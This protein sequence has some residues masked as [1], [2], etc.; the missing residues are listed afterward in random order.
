MP[1]PLHVGLTGG[2][3]CGKSQVLRRL[4]SVGLRTLD[5]DVVAHEVMAPGGPA[6]DEVVEAFGRAIL[7]RDGA[8]DR[9]A[10][11]ARVFRDEAARRRLNAIVH[12]WVWREEA[13][14]VAAWSE[15]PGAAAVTDAALLVESGLHLRFDRLVVVHC[16]PEVQLARLMARDGIDEGAARARLGAQMPVEEKRRFAHFEVATDAS[17]EETLRQADALATALRG[18]SG[19][20]RRPFTLSRTAALGSLTHGPG[21]GPRGLD[22]PMALRDIARAGGIEMER[23][24]SLLS[25]EAPAPWYRAALESEEAPP[26]AA[27]AGALALWQ[28]ARGSD[29]E[30]ALLAALASVARLTHRSAEA[31]G[32]ACVLGL[33]TLA[34][35]LDTPATASPLLERLPAW[36]SRA[37]PWAGGSFRDELGPVLRASDQ[38]PFD[39]ERARSSARDAGGDPDLAGALVGLRTGV[40]GTEASR[41]VEEAVDVLPGLSGPRATG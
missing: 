21:R 7:S 37:E 3:A 38:H 13:R 8:I 1:A 36:R 6:Y 39:L 40:V 23:L 10:L 29:D 15:E 20:P 14:R 28:M 17:L 26:P 32:N 24:R 33:A 27:L 41:E 5:L 11:G 22:P 34:A 2:I 30:D 31:I 19:R 16:R 35:A 25:P 18:L 9:K 12:P 4:A